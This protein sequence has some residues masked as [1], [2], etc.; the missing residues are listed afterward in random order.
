MQDFLYSII[1]IIAV[2]IHIIINPSLFQRKSWRSN[3]SKAYPLLMFAIFTYYITDACW[4][5]FA[6]LNN[7]PALFIDTT[8]YYV[9]MAA[10]VT[11]WLTYI[12]EYL[13]LNSFVSKVFKYLGWAFFFADIVA[14]LIN[15]FYPCFFWFDENDAYQAGVIRYS[16]LWI[17]VALFFVTVLITGWKTVHISG[18]SQRRHIAIFLFSIVMLLA[19]YFQILYPLLPIYAMGC[20]VGC[21]ILHVYVVEDEREEYRQIIA[22]EKELAEE[23]SRAKTSFLFSMSHDIRT[24]MNAILGYTLMARKKTNDPAIDDYLK[25]IDIA[26]NQLLSL[27][28]QVLEMSR[29]E[30][31][32]IV[33]QEQKIDMNKGAEVVRSVYAPQTEA[34]DIKLSVEVRNLEHTHVIGD[35]DRLSQITNNLVGNAVKYSMDG[36]CVSTY[37]EEEPCDKP[38]YAI[39]KMTV[40]DTGIGMSKEFIPHIFEEF[41]REETSTVSKIQGS[42]LGMS[43]VKQMVDLM[44]GTIEVSSEVN[45]GSKFVVRIPLKID[46][47]YVETE[48]TDEDLLSVS[49]EGM[50]ILLVEDN[51]M[52]REIAQDIL[53]E[54]GVLIDTA[55]NGISA[56]EMV[57]NSAS[58]KF[59][60]ILMD[61]QMP[62]I[63]GYEATRRIRALDN[64]ELASTVIFAM[65]AN[66]FAEDR[67]N[68]LNAGMNGHL[69]KPIDLPNLLR[70][71]SSLSK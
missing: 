39:Y 62:G 7:I 30:S 66:A 16:A 47:E 41:S 35:N 25:K 56:V 60:A 48:N 15:F 28:N 63:D 1:S 44:D 57:K 53:S 12:V 42:G 69:T 46:T 67:Q 36:G 13:E 38:G 5:M 20:L 61:I 11:C 23:A 71:L 29:I 51:E 3:R 10:A 70:T 64:P 26:G 54:A 49:L 40:E 50:H 37:V 58:A 52:N 31:G 14:L 21:C 8:L 24:P 68:A 45:V 34:K 9:A 19:N 33:L 55:D 4:G 27:V 65:T 43:I 18:S 22:E 6:G 17:Q 2:I 32:K 59:D